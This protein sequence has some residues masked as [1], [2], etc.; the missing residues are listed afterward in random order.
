MYM[1]H[2]FTRSSVNGHL[3]CLHVLAIVNS[4]A[5]NVGVNVSF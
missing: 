5:M 1:D 4:A 2:I 3:D